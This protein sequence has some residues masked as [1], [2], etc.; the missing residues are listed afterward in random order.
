MLSR[1]ESGNHYLT[2]VGT[3]VR[4]WIPSPLLLRIARCLYLA[5]PWPRRLYSETG[6]FAQKVLNP[7]NLPWVVIS[8]AF[9]LTLAEPAATAHSQTPLIH[10]W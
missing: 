4:P 9:Y 10:R 3:A 8:N 7:T 6:D 5:F 2:A 1:I